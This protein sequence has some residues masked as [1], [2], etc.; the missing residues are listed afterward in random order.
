MTSTASSSVDGEFLTI[1]EVAALLHLSPATV[2]RHIRRG[3]LKALK[4]GRNYRI[5]RVDF[6]EMLVASVVVVDSSERVQATAE[7]S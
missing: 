3:N 2:W 6:E 1:P 7:Q 4:I 5:R